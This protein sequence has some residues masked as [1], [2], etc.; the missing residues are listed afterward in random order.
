MV[1]FRIQMCVLTVVKIHII[2]R[3]ENFL[4]E[5]MSGLIC[6]NGR[7]EED[8]LEK[9]K[10]FM[11]VVKNTFVTKNFFTFRTLVW[12]HNRGTLTREFDRQKTVPNVSK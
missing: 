4:H 1:K 3:K 11:N 10:P 5:K 2:R 6:M 12:L 9:I 7:E 8:Y